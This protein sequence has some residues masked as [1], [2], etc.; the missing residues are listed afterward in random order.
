[1]EVFIAGITDDWDGYLERMSHPAA[2]G[3]EPEIVMSVNLVKRPIT[4]FRLTLAGRSVEPIVTYGE[5][6]KGTPVNLLWSGAHYDV[7][8]PARQ[9][10][11][12]GL[13]EP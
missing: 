1:M 13:H 11:G 12:G 7:L 5:E 4:V 3:G 2:W 10:S 9:A 6:L 8:V